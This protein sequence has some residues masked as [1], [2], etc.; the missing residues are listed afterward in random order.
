MSDTPVLVAVG[1]GSRGARHEETIGRLV[2]AV[3]RTR[4]GLRVETGWLDLVRPALGEVLAGLDSP[5][6]LVPLLLGTGYHVR[7]DIPAVIAAAPGIPARVARAL[8]P[9]PLL[10]DALCD[11]LTEAGRAPG[12]AVV[13]AA[14]GSTDPGA[15]AATVRMA[16]LLARRLDAPVVPSYLCA[17]SPTPAEAVAV[18]RRRGHARVAVARY[19]LAPGFF[20]DRAAAAGGCVTAPPLGAHASVARLVLRRYDDAAAEVT[21]AVPPAGRCVSR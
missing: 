21:A 16:R 15:E 10:A 5:A 9:H 18:L 6:V 13:L 11:R 12:D 4:P 20:G 1:H 19:L 3:R 7:V 14:A 17:G 2:D 8:G